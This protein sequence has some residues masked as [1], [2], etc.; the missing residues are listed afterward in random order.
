MKL[1][2]AHV[3][4]YRSLDNKSLFI[5]DEKRINEI[6][7]NELKDN[8]FMVS[9]A[10]KLQ[11]VNGSGDFVLVMYFRQENPQTAESEN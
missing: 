10:S 7:E 3:R 6:I 11:F 5:E 8:F 9:T 1:T 2:K 4:I